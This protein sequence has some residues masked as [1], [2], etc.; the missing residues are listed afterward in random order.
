MKKY[1]TQHT[2]AAVCI[3]LIIGGGIGYV[4]EREVAASQHATR[5]GQFAGGSGQRMRGGGFVG[6]TILTKGVGSF[7]VKSLDGSS[8]IVLFGASTTVAKAAPG[9]MDDLIVGTTVVVT[10][11]VNSDQS[12]TAEN[13]QIRP[14]GSGPRSY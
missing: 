9:T 11:K 1:I 2:I 5:A 14:V 10:G 8:K 7:T 4:A 3:G 12:V 6:G 13:V